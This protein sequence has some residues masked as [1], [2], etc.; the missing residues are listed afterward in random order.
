[1]GLT[2]CGQ[3]LLSYKLSYDYDD[4]LANDFSSYHK[5]EYVYTLLMQSILFASLR[6]T[7]ASVECLIPFAGFTFG[8]TGRTC[9]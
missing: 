4:A 7:Y 1:M 6:T 9:C 8:F 3:F 5:Y 2:S